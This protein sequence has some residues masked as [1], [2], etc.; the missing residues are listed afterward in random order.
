MKTFL[1]VLFTMALL[2]GPLADS[3]VMA[4]SP[5]DASVAW[6]K[7]INGLV[8]GISC[9]TY[10]TNSATLLKIY[11]HLANV[12]DREI[13]GIIQRDRMCIV[14]VNGR[15]YAQRSWGGRFSWMPPGKKY[16]PI[17]IQSERLRRIPVLAVRPTISGSAPA[18]SVQEGTNTVSVYYKLGEKL[19]QSGEIKI[20][21]R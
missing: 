16:G 6:G 17:P 14:A 4:P 9:D 2:R 10:T 13:Q 18:P 15:Y 12:G 1:A 5:V 20:V 21:G 19:V 7:P 11:F 3:Q 8:V